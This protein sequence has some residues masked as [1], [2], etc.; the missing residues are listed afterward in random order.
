MKSDTAIKIAYQETRILELLDE[1]WQ[2]SG[3]MYSIA[4][5]LM[6]REQLK[7]QRLLMAVNADK[8][9][10]FDPVNHVR[11]QGEM[12]SDQSISLNIAVFKAL[13]TAD[14]AL[15]KS[16]YQVE[17][18]SKAQRWVMTLKPRQESNSEFSI[19]VTGL[20]GQQVD[21]VII[22]QTDGDLSEIMMQSNASGN[23]V[24]NTIMQL[25][26]ELEGK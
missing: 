26:K 9:Y 25:Y 13:I 16:M 21:T 14:E 20:R 24:K 18:S 2:G 23:Q 11:H 12:G 22:K 19:V 15:L 7:P 4:P 10:Y 3:F 8:L 5:D 1:P 17:F 6:I